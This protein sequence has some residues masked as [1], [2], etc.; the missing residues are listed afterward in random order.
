MKYCTEYAALLDLF[1]DGELTA[2]E[3]ADVQAHLDTC[4]GCR[5]YVEDAL[6]IRAAFPEVE[7]VEVPAGF[8]EGVMA[9][10]AAAPVKKQVR[11]NRLLKTVMPLAACLA[12]VIMVQ[13]S[14]SLDKANGALFSAESS[15]P[16]AAM[17]TAETPAAAP[18]AA[19]PMAPAAAPK[20]MPEAPE[21]D[22]AAEMKLETAP[23]AGAGSH[24]FDTMRY[25]ERLEVAP[26]GADLLAPFT[27]VEETESKITYFLTADECAILQTQLE[28]AGISYRVEPSAETELPTLVVL[29]K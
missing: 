25:G 10:I 11:K 5:A 17:E 13:K 29:K 6:E 19:A 1:V 12:V 18:A 14:P 24:A 21:E 4:P 23:T 15:A 27:I 8:A 7:D 3:M 26:E 2:A 22:G 9:R 20:A 28:E 16:S